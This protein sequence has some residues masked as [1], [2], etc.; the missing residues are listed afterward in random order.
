MPA[1]STAH[2]NGMTSRLN[3]CLAK[4]KQTEK[5]DEEAADRPHQPRPQLDQMLDQRRRRF[6]DFV[7]PRALT[8]ALP[9][10]SCCGRPWRGCL[11]AAS[12]S[13]LAAAAL[14]PAALRGGFAGW[15]RFAA[16]GSGLRLQPCDFRRR[17]LGHRRRRG[18]SRLPAAAT[19]SAS[20][21]APAPPASL[22]AGDARH[23]RRAVLQAA[24]PAAASS[25][26]RGRIGGLGVGFSAASSPERTSAAAFSNGLS[27]FLISAGRIEA[28]QLVDRLLHV[29]ELG[30]L[31]RLVELLLEI[32]GH[33][34]Q[35]RRRL[36]EGA[37]H[38][39]ANPSAR[40]P[41]S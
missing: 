23:R 25:R 29:V 13:A 39:A 32:A 5:G 21:E 22:R 41:R 38:A 1:H 9:S 28:A 15:R 34:A 26:G 35:L 31:Q 4:K 24:R 2:L 18:R 30:L 27:C 37:Q 10:S 11:A 36:A 14:L 3:R 6:L 33:G 19:A 7:C 8:S 20:P 12:A 17:R 16:A 40:R